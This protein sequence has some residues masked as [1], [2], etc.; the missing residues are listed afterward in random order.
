VSRAILL[1]WTNP[2]EGREDDFNHWYSE[3]HVHD[4]VSVDGFVSAQRFEYADTHVGDPPDYRY[5]AIY[6]I[7]APSV[8]VAKAALRAAR[9]NGVLRPSDAMAKERHAWY[10]EP[11][12]DAVSAP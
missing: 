8:E 7:D 1:V 9:D 2:V 4:V 11:M 6:E 10:F 12:S 5:L 3:Q